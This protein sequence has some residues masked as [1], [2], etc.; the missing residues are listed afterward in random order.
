M[1]YL[2]TLG[3]WHCVLC[4]ALP[5]IK[6][7]LY[8]DFTGNHSGDVWIVGDSLVRWAQRPLGVSVPVLWRGRSGACLFIWVPMIYLVLMFFCSAIYFH[9]YG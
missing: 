7:Y 6:W 3:L 5:W 1:L 9:F 2:L 8:L 4:Q